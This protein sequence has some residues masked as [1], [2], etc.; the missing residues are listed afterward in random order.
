[1]DVTFYAKCM[2]L[3]DTQLTFCCNNLKQNDKISLKKFHQ[4]G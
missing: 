1:M 2:Q 3:P 4:G